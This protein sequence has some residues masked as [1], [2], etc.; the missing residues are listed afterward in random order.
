[1]NRT[2]RT[3]AIAGSLAA[4]VLGATSAMAQ[5]PAAGE[6][7]AVDERPVPALAA[8]TRL[9]VRQAA[10]DDQASAHRVNGERVEAY[11]RTPS[12]LTRA[13]VRAEGLNALRSGTLRVGDAG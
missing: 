5:T 13:E 2:I 7:S 12:Q 3:L 1:M 8:E 4:S 9:A 11:T 6:F 10:Q